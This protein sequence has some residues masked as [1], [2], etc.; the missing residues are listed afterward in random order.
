MVPRFPAG[1]SRNGVYHRSVSAD[2]IEAALI[3][4]Q[5]WAARLR[6]DRIRAEQYQTA[7]QRRVTATVLERALQ[8]GA[9]AVALTG[10]TARAR[11]TEISDLDIHVVGPRPRF[12]DLGEGVDVCATSAEVLWQRLRAGDDYV[13][14]TLRFGCILFDSGVLRQALREVRETGLWP[15]PARK[16]V[17]AR[18]LLAFAARVAATGDLDAAQDQARAALTSTA[19]WLLLANGVF[20]LA[21]DELSDQVLALGCFDL[22]AALA[23][24]RHADPQFDELAAAL[25]IGRLVTSLPPRRAR[26]AALPA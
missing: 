12:A 22:A 21:R 20:P 19:R 26:R 24:L 10:S 6:D 25:E 4:D 17:R 14:W 16:L 23:R 1:R 13:Q 9:D 2:R 18:D 8:A 7:A 11:R 5:A 15:D 3:E